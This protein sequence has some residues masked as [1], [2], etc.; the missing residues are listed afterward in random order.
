M[1]NF[2][3]IQNVPAI[4]YDWRTSKF[5][6]NLATYKEKV[7]KLE[8][9]EVKTSFVSKI[10][11][12]FPFKNKYFP[13]KFTESASTRVEP[14]IRCSLVETQTCWF[15]GILCIFH[16]LS[17]YLSIYISVPHP[18]VFWYR[19]NGMGAQ[20]NDPKEVLVKIFPYIFHVKSK[21]NIFYEYLK[22]KIFSRDTNIL[23]QMH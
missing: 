12:A 15:C 14:N 1:F 22:T 23:P 20:K 4:I 16:G 5:L 21:W 7:N 8:L 9:V 17:T 6:F 2:A 10:N 11:I 19:L 18:D 13:R 3:Q